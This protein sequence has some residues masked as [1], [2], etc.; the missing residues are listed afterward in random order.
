MPWGAIDDAIQAD[1]GKK[2]CGRRNAANTRTAV[3]GV[4]VQHGYFQLIK[5]TIQLIDKVGYVKSCR[6]PK[7][8]FRTVLVSPSPLFPV[9][10][11]ACDGATV[12]LIEGSV[13]M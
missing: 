2:V 9:N 10:F 11:H 5:S 6:H 3:V 8:I 12:C 4:R 13:D 7:Y 1:D